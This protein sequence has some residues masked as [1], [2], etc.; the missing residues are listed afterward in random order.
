MAKLLPFKP[1]VSIGDDREPTVLELDGDE[2]DAVFEA[3]SAR[4]ARRMLTALYEEPRAAS[5]LTD[6]ADTSLQNVQYHLDKLR[7]AGLIEVADTWYSETGTEMKVYAP[8]DSAVVLFASEESGSALRDAL[9][10]LLGGLAVLAP[11]ALL[12]RW[13]VDRLSPDEPATEGMAGGGDGGGD[14]VDIA[15][16]PRAT[17]TADAPPADPLL[18]D[19]A[20]VLGDP[21]V[22]FLLGGLLVLAL[23]AAWRYRSR[24]D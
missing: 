20:A 7:D 12:V 22:A 16:T 2:A 11:A 21:G 24:V 18:A 10:T 8:T 5:D 15:T 4:T 13:A 14:D 23:A 1:A 6:V 17:E 19:L 9:R 3:L